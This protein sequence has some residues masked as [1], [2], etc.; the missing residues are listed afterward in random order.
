MFNKKYLFFC[1][2]AVLLAVLTFFLD[3]PY[4]YKKNS[5]SSKKATTKTIEQ[6]IWVTVF[7]HGSFGTLLGLLSLPNVVSDNVTDT[8]YHQITKR[9]RNDHTFYANQP[10]QK[11]GLVRI[12]P[13]LDQTLSMN[14]K[15]GAYPII[16]AYDLVSHA[17]KPHEKNLFYTF[18]WSGLVSQHRRRLESIRLYNSLVQEI[19]TIK[20]QGFNPKIRLIA[21]SHGG[22]ICLNL[23]TIPFLMK[24][25]DLSCSHEYS[26]H[27]DACE[28]L[29]KMTKILNALPK[30]CNTSN[31]ASQKCYDY[32]PLRDNLH[33]DELILLGT[34]IQV[35]TERFA[36]ADFFKRIYNIYS[37][38]DIVQELDWVSTKQRISS[39]RINQQ[40]LDLTHTQQA[41]LHKP[42]ITQAK[43][44]YERE[45]SKP[46]T[47]KPTAAGSEPLTAQNSLWSRILKSKP[48]QKDPSHKDL[49]FFSWANTT[50][51]Q[52]S[53]VTPLPTVI[54]IPFITA[55]MELCPALNDVDIN[56]ISLDDNVIAQVHKHAHKHHEA[57]I[58]LPLTVINAIKSK[59]NAWSPTGKVETSEELS[60]AYLYLTQNSQFSSLIEELKNSLP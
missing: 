47:T 30:Q 40:V 27:S 46:S 9:M 48:S 34:P 4:H 10:I 35:E 3:I 13:S 29:E 51:K 11:K 6:E 23:A 1:F 21:H 5:N 33:I 41:A 2:T 38:K 58:T 19:D 43:I 56:L 31:T 24:N 45:A 44:I 16:K 57:Q 36:S 7:V 32:L 59:L 22:N 15:I 14:K 54:F 20:E 17:I 18:G 39:Q 37:E 53:F 52:K 26:D 42:C 50:S 28:S 49:W 60:K 25:N 55:A 12:Y 8:F